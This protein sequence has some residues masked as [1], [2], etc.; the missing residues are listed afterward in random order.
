MESLYHRQ[1]HAKS[2][3][4]K[5][6]E[7]FVRWRRAEES[8]LHPGLSRSAG[9]RDQKAL[10]SLRALRWNGSRESNPVRAVLQ[11]A[12]SS[13]SASPT[14]HTR[15]ELNL[16]SQFWRLL[17]SPSGQVRGTPGRS[18]TCRLTLVLSE[19]RLPIPPREYSWWAG[20][21]SNSHAEAPRPER[22]VSTNSTTGPCPGRVSNPQNC[23]SQ[24]QASA[25]LRHLDMLVR[26][27]GLEP[28]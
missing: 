20:G 21:D 14:W 19:P 15:E 11:T 22:G 4:R 7:F 26:A 9:F 12:A 23:G 28:T 16:E 13:V 18:R 6:Q 1:F 2:T 3:N 24:P 25:N 8:N 10:P 27:V 5:T 17:P